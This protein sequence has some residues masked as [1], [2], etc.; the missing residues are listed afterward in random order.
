MYEIINSHHIISSCQFFIMNM[1][2][3]NLS[4]KNIKLNWYMLVSQSCPTLYDPWTAACQVPLSVG[5]SRQEP[6]VGCHFLLQGIF[7]TQRSNLGL[8]HCRQ[9]LHCQP[10]GRTNE[11]E[12]NTKEVLM[13]LITV[14]YGCPWVVCGCHYPWSATV[15]SI[16][17]VFLGQRKPVSFL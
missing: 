6:R 2:L 12:S 14:R 4:N 9:I 3:W 5:F 8:L 10:P 16:Q 13:V 15:L 7:P 1:A 11:L 17:Y